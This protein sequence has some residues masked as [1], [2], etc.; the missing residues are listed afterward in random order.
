MCRVIVRKDIS[1]LQEVKR[2]HVENAQLCNQEAKLL[3]GAEE[4]G[5]ETTK[6]QFSSFITKR[7]IAHSVN[8]MISNKTTK[9]IKAQN[10]PIKLLP[11][12]G[13]KLKVAYTSDKAS[14]DT[15]G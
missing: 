4:T 2:I 10:R 15:H 6:A 13:N 12:N 9:P 11:W 5:K 14:K 1:I 8:K 7:F 3:A